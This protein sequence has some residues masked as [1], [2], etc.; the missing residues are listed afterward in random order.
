MT[1]EDVSKAVLDVAKEQDDEQYSGVY[2]LDTGVRVRVKPIPAAVIDEVTAR[3]PQPV[4]PKWYDKEI[5]R[6]IENP[7]DPAYIRALEEYDRKRGSAMIDACVMFG[8]DLVDG[9]PDNDK[10]LAKFKFSE[11]MG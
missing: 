9:L 3:I 10:W 8:L 11:K 2:T 4:V 7:S 1:D 6:E 5:E